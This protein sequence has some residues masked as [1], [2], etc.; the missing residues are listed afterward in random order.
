[1]CELNLGQFANLLR[2]Q[3]PDAPVRSYHKV[4]GQPFGI[5]EVK[6]KIRNA[7]ANI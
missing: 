1:V 6:E 3:F 5:S 7:L 4:Q 2:M